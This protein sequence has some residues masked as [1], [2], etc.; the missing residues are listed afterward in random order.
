MCS[1]CLFVGLHRSMNIDMD[2]DMYV[3]VHVY[4]NYRTMYKHADTYAIYFMCELMESGILFQ[5]RCH[6]R[7]FCRAHL[8]QA[9]NPFSDAIT[10]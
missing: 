1:L 5:L 10:F 6:F 4:A 3:H 8:C 7:T 2:M 9:F